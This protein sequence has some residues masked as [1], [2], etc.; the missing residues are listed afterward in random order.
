[1]PRSLGF[2]LLVRDLIGGNAASVA[3]ADAADVGER[4]EVRD[5]H[6]THACAVQI[7]LSQVHVFQELQT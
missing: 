2:P 1:M 5:A 3:R 7:H 6:Q 4:Q